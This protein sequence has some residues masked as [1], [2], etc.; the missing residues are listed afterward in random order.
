MKGI[1][2]AALFIAVVALLAL[3][4][5]RP[6]IALAACGNQYMANNAE[7][8]INI[9][10]WVM[11]VDGSCGSTVIWYLYDTAN[12]GAGWKSVQSGGTEYLLDTATTLTVHTGSYYYI[13]DACDTNCAPEF[14]FYVYARINPGL[15]QIVQ[16]AAPASYA[17]G[18]QDARFYLETKTS[19]TA[20]PGSDCQMD[21]AFW[22]SVDDMDYGP[23]WYQAGFFNYH[24]DSAGNYTL[25]IN[26]CG[27]PWSPSGINPFIQTTLPDGYLTC[28]VGIYTPGANGDQNSG[29]QGDAESFNITPGETI[30][31]RFFQPDSCHLELD[32]NGIKFATS[33]DCSIGGG[34]EVDGEHPTGGYQTG[35]YEEAHNDGTTDTTNTSYATNGVFAFRDHQVN[36]NYISPSDGQPYAANMTK[37]AYSCVVDNNQNPAEAPNFETTTDFNNHFYEFQTGTFQGSSVC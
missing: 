15:A 28:W 12:P 22:G 24:S 5:R 34:W 27:T 21:D 2:I 3:P 6:G 23:N 33:Y 19:G 36:F 11:F 13:L 25:G 16:G 4:A 10:Q 1:K 29:C 18:T 14:A 31:Y 17:N 9:G 37:D 26:S 32:V 20:L 8:A 30:Q 35:V 7:P